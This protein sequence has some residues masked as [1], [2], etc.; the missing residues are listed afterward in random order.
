MPNVSARPFRPPWGEV[1]QMPGEVV[2]SR[3]V[4]DRSWWICSNSSRLV[5]KRRRA[6]AMSRTILFWVLSCCPLECSWWA[7]VLVGYVP[8]VLT[9]LFLGVF[10]KAGVLVGGSWLREG[11]V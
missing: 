3:Y 11:Y 5:G 9:C 8:R 6:S 4:F 2:E 1:E 7:M 10:W